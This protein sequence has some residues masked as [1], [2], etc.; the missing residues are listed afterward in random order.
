MYMI[1]AGH[2]VVIVSIIFFLMA[3]L[4]LRVPIGN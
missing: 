3:P 2:M 4:S 1:D